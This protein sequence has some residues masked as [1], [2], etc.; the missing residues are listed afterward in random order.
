MS[1][2]W[3][4]LK[5]ILYKPEKV[6]TLQ[7]DEDVIFNGY[8]V[9][10][11]STALVVS[12][13]ETVRGVTDTNRNLLY[14]TGSVGVE[15]D[16]YI[17]F[18]VYRDATFAIYDNA[19]L[20]GWNQFDKYGIVINGMSAYPQQNRFNLCALDSSDEDSTNIGQTIVTDSLNNHVQISTT[21]EIT[22]V[23]TPPVFNP[24]VG[25]K[26]WYRLGVSSA[27]TGKVLFN[28]FLWVNELNKVE[29]LFETLNGTT[30]FRNNF[31]V[32]ESPGSSWW[33]KTDS[34]FN[35]SN[36]PTLYKYDNTY[37][38]GWK[39]F[40][41]YGII[42]RGMTAYPQYKTFNF[43]ASEYYAETTTNSGNLC[44]LDDAANKTIVPV[45]FN[46]TPTANPIEA[47][48]L[49]NNK[50]SQNQ[51]NPNSQNKRIVVS[52]CGQ[53]S[54]GESYQNYLMGIRHT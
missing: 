3:Y 27:E 39:Q 32:R 30:N 1:F 7:K 35:I 23:S 54:P 38:G 8:F 53:S 24:A 41:Y 19:Y 5:V 2:S 13:Y 48:A 14:A 42:F 29:G 49:V 46:I 6:D 20:N 11:N 15:W 33:G 21:F 47:Q 45:I 10:D 16:S 40:D 31:I 17:G 25:S 37:V 52:M 43:S 4:S 44:I 34:G 36:Q 51:N 22:Q 28:G 26:S 9:V 50:R 12:V 18:T